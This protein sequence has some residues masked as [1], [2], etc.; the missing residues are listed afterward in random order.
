[1]GD[2]PLHPPSLKLLL[3]SLEVSL[4]NS[5]AISGKDPRPGEHWGRC[6]AHFLVDGY[7]Y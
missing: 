5:Y 7:G 2:P 6:L 1:M 3:S 4:G